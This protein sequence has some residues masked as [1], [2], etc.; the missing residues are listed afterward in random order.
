[1]TH[2]PRHR[3]ILCVAL[4]ATTFAACGDS[5]NGGGDSVPATFTVSPGV[6]QVTVTGAEPKQAL[7]LIDSGGRRLITLIADTGGNATFANIPD[8]YTVYETG[9]G[10]APLT[11]SG[12]TLRPGSGYTIRD[13]S[14]SPMPT[15]AE[16]RV[17]ARDE[18][19]DPSLYERQTLVGV[20]WQIIGGVLPGHEVEEGAG[21]G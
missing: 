15:S 19:P 2:A 16:F 14:K 9:T 17:L 10:A 8:D 13:E 1:M 11:G 6:R 12:E 18:H 3:Y 4:L 7:T 20:P 5:S 21:V